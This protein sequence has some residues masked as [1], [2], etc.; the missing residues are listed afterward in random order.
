MKKPQ[1]LSWMEQVLLL[2]ERGMLV[3][4]GDAKTLQCI[5]YYRIKEFAAPLAFFDKSKQEINYGGISFSEVLKRYYQ[6]KNLRFNLLHAIEQIEVA[7]KTKLA[8]ILGQYYGPYGYL[9]FYQWTN[10]EKFSNFQIEK[11][12]YRFK[13]QLL[14]IIRKSNMP[15]LKK[16][17]N[18]NQDGF[19]TVWLAIDSLMFGGLVTIITMISKKNL[20]K[21]AAYFNCTG[22]ELVSWVKCLNFIRNICAHNSNVIDFKLNTVP[23]IRKNWKEDLYSIKGKNGLRPT[24]RLA[25]V[26]FILVTLVGA[27]NSKYRWKDINNNIW[28]I[29]DSDDNKAQMIGFKN[30]ESAKVQKIV[31]KINGP[32]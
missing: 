32:A 7:I 21:L 15:D 18:Q 19:P 26:I 10:R 14:K 28:N 4:K 25:V 13:E 29:C 20:K 16:R 9:D 17:E 6:D 3:D 23:V 30:C 27:V 31:D 22:T 24:N 12:Q 1:E 11:R 2:Q 5:S 8:Y